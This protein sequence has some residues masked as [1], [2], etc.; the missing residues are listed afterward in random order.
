MLKRNPSRDQKRRHGKGG[1][2]QLVAKGAR[3]GPTSQRARATKSGELA[4]GQNPSG[5]LLFLEEQGL[6]LAFA[7]GALNRAI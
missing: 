6:H 2:G 1:T 4:M 3:K 7:A 5:L